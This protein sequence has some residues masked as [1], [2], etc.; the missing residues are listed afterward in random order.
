MF[1]KAKILLRMH[2]AIGLI[3]IFTVSLHHKAPC[4]VAAKK[5]KKV[6]VVIFRICILRT[7]CLILYKLEK[8]SDSRMY[9]ILI[10]AQVLSLVRHRI[11]QI[12]S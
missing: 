4:L 12:I 11:S 1:A 10:N 5:K 8:K 9:H 6:S 3:F 7:L 2:V